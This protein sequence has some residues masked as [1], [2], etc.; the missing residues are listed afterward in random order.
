MYS[1]TFGDHCF[2][3]RVPLNKTLCELFS[4]LAKHTPQDFAAYTLLMANKPSSCQFQYGFVV[5]NVALT[6]KR[7]GLSSDDSE[8]TV[9]LYLTH[10]E[11]IYFVGLE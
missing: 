7:W 1:N 10:I 8:F 2:T 3:C 11:G 6:K 4:P 5:H 9:S